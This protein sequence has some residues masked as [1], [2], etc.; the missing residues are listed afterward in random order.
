VI[1]S[2]RMYGA[3]RR[4]S[5]RRSVPTREDLERRARTHAL[6]VVSSYVPAIKECIDSQIP[7]PSS[8]ASEQSIRTQL[9]KRET[10][11]SALNRIAYLLKS[12][13]YGGPVRRADLFA[14]YDSFRETCSQLKIPVAEPH[15][16]AAHADER[17]RDEIRGIAQFL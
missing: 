9:E 6:D 1:N 15:T 17:L 11:L 5:A 14:A 16:Q 7:A 12:V 10:V 8:D 13:A 4:D 3:A 2:G